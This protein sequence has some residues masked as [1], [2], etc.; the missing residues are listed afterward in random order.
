MAV[1]QALDGQGDVGRAVL[2][3]GSLPQNQIAY[4]SNLI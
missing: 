1:L 2:H 4:I 3:V